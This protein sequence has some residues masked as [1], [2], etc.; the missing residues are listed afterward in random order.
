MRN[1]IVIVAVIDIACSSRKAQDLSQVD[2]DM[3][4]EAHILY[5]EDTID[6]PIAADSGPPK[7]LVP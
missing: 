1:G 2:D 6:K 7:D 3:E 5:M 4:V